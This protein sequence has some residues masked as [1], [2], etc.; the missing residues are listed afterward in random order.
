M[1]ENEIDSTI[2]E[3]NRQKD[4]LCDYG[5]SFVNIGRYRRN[6][7]AEI[8]SY[9]RYLEEQVN[10]II[11]EILNPYGTNELLGEI[12]EIEIIKNIGKYEYDNVYSKNINNNDTASFGLS[13]NNEVR[14]D[15]YISF[16][17]RFFDKVINSIRTEASNNR[18]LN[19]EEI[20]E[21]TFAM[22]IE[23][24]QNISQTGNFPQ[25]NPRERVNELIEMSQ[26]NR[27]NNHLAP[28]SG[29]I[30]AL[31]LNLFRAT[32]IQEEGTEI[33][34]TIFRIRYAALIDQNNVQ[35]Q[36]TVNS[37]QEM[38]S[39]SEKDAIITVLRQRGENLSGIYN[40]CI[41]PFLSTFCDDTIE[42]PIQDFCLKIDTAIRNRG[43]LREEEE[44]ELKNKIEEYLQNM[45]EEDLNIIE[46]IVAIEE[47]RQSLN[48]KS[49]F[50]EFGN[51]INE[52][53]NNIK[54]PQV[55]R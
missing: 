24:A 19:V 12:L 5:D 6:F 23:E 17:N 35:R 49:L 10:P 26:R 18:E 25:K 29:L 32:G 51:F 1:G 40:N 45:S 7:Y 22:E 53:I 2:S 15:A 8:I 21:D 31:K 39:E 9:V 54:N 41:K 28:A 48:E 16:V 3:L 50:N 11:S 4:I 42:D 55:T 20:I 33:I 38:F 30:E 47:V 44:N 14:R 52:K 34:D 46:A 27:G 36:N 43:A 13:Y 37:N